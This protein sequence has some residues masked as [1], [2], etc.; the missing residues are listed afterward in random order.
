M[1]PVHSLH[2][3]LVATALGLL[4]LSGC[5]SEAEHSATGPSGG[6]PTHASDT[7]GHMGHGG[8]GSVPRGMEPATDPAFPVGSSVILTA[9]HMPGMK[10]ARATV[11]GAYSTITYAVTYQPTTGGPVVTNHKWV[12]QEEIKGA[13]DERIPTGSEVTLTA[14]HMPGMKGA[15]ATI[16]GSTEQTVYVVDY[17]VNQKTIQN[18]RWVVE[19]EM[20]AVPEDS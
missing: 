19:S 12:V 1:L 2:R 11:E 9:G 6:T 4:V 7:A 16:V 8:G 14:D 5:S 20:K 17:T 13:G 18:H 3:Y 10:G 15:T